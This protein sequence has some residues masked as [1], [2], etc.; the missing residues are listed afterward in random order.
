MHTDCLLL[1][2]NSTQGHTRHRPEAGE[3]CRDQL[4]GQCCGSFGCAGKFRHLC[5]HIHRFYRC[6]YNKPS[7]DLQGLRRFSWCLV[8][9]LDTDFWWI[10]PMPDVP[11]LAFCFGS[12]ESS[13]WL[14]LKLSNQLLCHQRVQELLVQ[15]VTL[16]E[17]LLS[18]P[19]VLRCTVPC[20]AHSTHVKHTCQLMHVYMCIYIY[21]YYIYY[22]Y[23]INSIALQ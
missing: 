23:D 19:R 10:L 14:K 1:P 11:P 3:I 6:K 22:I 20:K 7:P 17:H 2:V 18:M 13:L 16:V 9:I 5:S 8:L 4:W 21:I 12:C 15:P